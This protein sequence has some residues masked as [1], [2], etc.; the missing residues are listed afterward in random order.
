M[1]LNNENK[2]KKIYNRVL[3]IF[4]IILLIILVGIG[5]FY[6]YKMISA[7]E[8]NNT[9]SNYDEEFQNEIGQ[10][11]NIITDASDDENILTDA[12]EN[13]DSA[14]ESSS[15]S[16]S[17]SS[18]KS[19]K[20]N[21]VTYARK[22]RTKRVASKYYGYSVSGYIRIPKTG[23]KYPIL[24]ELTKNGLEKGVCIEWGPGPNEPGNTVIAGHNYLNRLFFSRNDR[25]NNGDKIY[26]T[27]LYGVTVEY[28][29][30]N[31]YNTTPED[32]S[33]FYR[34]TGGN[35]EITL[36][37]CSHNGSQRLIIWAK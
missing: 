12:K 34:D 10:D 13:G 20:K 33:Y 30:Y 35:P 9:A 29:I 32:T 31:K 14:K 8:I 11:E 17:S 24:T 4:L 25:L 28:T 1:A 23:V 5:G 21:K 2:A 15:N 16:N 19:S 18:K 26:I 36:A 37:T 7:K 22:T 6:A 27:D 3:N